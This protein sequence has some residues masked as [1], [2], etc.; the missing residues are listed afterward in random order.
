MPVNTRRTIYD[1]VA[2]S[3]LPAAER[4]RIMADADSIDDND[5]EAAARTGG[6]Q[7]ACCR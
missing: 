5:A 4:R 7:R 3:H 6:D 1:R 2:T